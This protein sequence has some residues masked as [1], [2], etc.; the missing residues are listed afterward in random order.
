MRWE[1]LG[2]VFSA[3]V[4]AILSLPERDAFFCTQRCERK[5]RKAFAVEMKDCLQACVTLSN[6]MD[7]IN[8]PMVGLLAKNVISQ[9][10][11]SGDTSK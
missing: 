9:T 8:L 5:D 1:T 3:L 4:Q 2:I 11:I 7:L 10:I 6:W